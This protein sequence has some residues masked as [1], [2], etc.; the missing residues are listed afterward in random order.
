V[1][2]TSEA[3]VELGVSERTLRR[4][5]TA[6]LIGYRQ[7]PGG[8]YRIPREAIDE[9]WREHSPSPRRTARRQR[10]AARPPRARAVRETTAGEPGRRPRLSATSA[11]R[12]YEVPPAHRIGAIA[13]DPPPGAEQN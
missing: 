12:S 10:L 7:L 2:S 8:H 13:S 6:G 3:A 5:I 4:Y 9:F 11:P 1:F